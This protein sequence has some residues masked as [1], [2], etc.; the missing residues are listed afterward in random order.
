M[1]LHETNNEKRRAG[2]SGQGEINDFAGGVTAPMD[3]R[4]RDSLGAAGATPASADPFR[5]IPNL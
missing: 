4:L 5:S 2:N 1:D 3:L